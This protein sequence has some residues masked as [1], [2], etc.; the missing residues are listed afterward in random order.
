MYRVAKDIRADVWVANDW[1]MLPLAARLAGEYGGVYVY[2]AHELAAH[3]C[4]EHLRWR[5]F[6][7]PL[8]VTLERQFI[9][10]AAKVWTVSEGIADN[11]EK[12]YRLPEHPLVIRNVPRYTA[13]PFRQTGSKI[14][15]LYHGIVVPNR[16]LEAIIESV[17]MWRPEFSLTIRGPAHPDYLRKLHALAKKLSVQ[18]RVEFA[19]PVPMANLVSEAAHFD[20]GFSALPG[21]SLNNQYALP[22]KVF[23]YIMAGLALCVSSLPEV[24]RLLDDYRLG[25]K[26]DRV[27]PKVIACA[28]NSLTPSTIDV[29]KQNAL[30]A[31]RELNWE[32]ESMK[33]IR[34][35]GTLA[36]E[37]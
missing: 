37:A 17:G 8:V 30:Q 19:K 6:R 29:Y 12:A 26:F 9:T 25:V 16:G 3:E 28:I 2:D 20:I 4:T 35:F 5:I 34:A 18:E 14:K 13:V 32:R 21:S 10:G 24:S 36:A 15:V 33:L 7:R 22:N 31:A 23:E 11:L 1:I 27:Q